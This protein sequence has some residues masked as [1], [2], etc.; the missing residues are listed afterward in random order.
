MT[1][2]GEDGRFLIM[3][4]EFNSNFSRRLASDKYNKLEI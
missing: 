3:K 2:G 4:S 1:D